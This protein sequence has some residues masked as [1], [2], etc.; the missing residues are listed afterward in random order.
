MDRY[1]TIKETSEKLK[2]KEETI[3]VWLR[4]KR[5]K[6]EKFGRKW[7]INDPIIKL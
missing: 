6:G 2:V 3:R 7:L 4:K 5:I 1:L